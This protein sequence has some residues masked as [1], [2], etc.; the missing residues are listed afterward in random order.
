MDR[1]LITW[2]LFLV[3]LSSA[4]VWAADYLVADVKAQRRVIV[5]AETEGVVAGYEARIGDQV[6]ARATLVQLDDRD[7][8]LA[9]AI[10]EAQLDLSRAEYQSQQRQLDRMKQLAAKHSVAE[11]ELD[12]QR[13]KAEVSA[14]RVALDERLLDQARRK[15]EKTRLTA[16][17]A[18]LV[19]A[20]HVE[21]GQWVGPGAPLYELVAMETI[22]VQLVL[23]EQDT[24]DLKVGDEMRV[25]IPSLD[26]HYQATVNRISPALSADSKGYLAELDLDNQDLAIRP[27]YRAEVSPLA[28]EQ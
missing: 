7:T 19:M 23:I 18:G 6:D 10:A 22:K 15:S 25:Y 26:R 1:V 16:P 17:F 21:L 11:S 20:R 13:R 24:V 8:T 5:S 14:A 27:G 28:S 2:T 3:C 4:Q 12:E 9:V